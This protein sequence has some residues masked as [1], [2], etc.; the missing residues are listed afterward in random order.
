MLALSN[1]LEHLRPRFDDVLDHVLGGEGRERFAHGALHH[2][3][4]VADP[5]R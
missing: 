5:V 4:L 3:N 1:A 2:R